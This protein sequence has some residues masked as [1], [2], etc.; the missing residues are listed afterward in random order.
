[1]NQ[2]DCLNMLAILSR[3]TFQGL[4][5]ATAGVQL[6]EKLRRMIEEQDEQDSPSDS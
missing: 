6:A 1:M 5:E 2:R 4:E 3:T